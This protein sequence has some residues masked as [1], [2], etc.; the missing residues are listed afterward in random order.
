MGIL[1]RIYPPR[2]KT[3]LLWAVAFA[4][5][6]LLSSGGAQPYAS[7]SLTSSVLLLPADV[8]FDTG[9]NLFFSD[10]NRHVVQR[11]DPAGLVTIV[12]GS[13]VQGYAG[14]GGPALAAQLDCPAGLAVDA[15]GNLYIADTHNHRVRRV[16]GATGNIVTVAGTGRAGFTG[17]GGTAT[18]ARLDLP[19]A[20][21][22]DGTGNLYIADTNNHRVRRVAVGTGL[23][24]TVAGNGSQGFAGDGGSAT[25]A[26]IDS[27]GGVAVDA[28]GNLYIADAHNQR[29][30]MV[31]AKTGLISTV[32]GTGVAGFAGDGALAVGAQLA[33]PHGVSVDGAGNVY[34]ADTN[35]HRVR[36]IAPDG[37]MT[38]VAGD[39]VQAFRGDGGPAV[40]ASLN[41]PRGLAVSPTGLPTLADS[42]NQRVRQVEADRTIVTLAGVG[43]GAVP[44]VPVAPETLTLS[45]PE[46]VVY[47]SGTLTATLSAGGQA[48]GQ[49]T[50]YEG[51]GTTLGSV[52]VN[53]GQAAF[54]TGA[55]SAGTHQVYAS[56]AG[57]SAHAAAT[58]ATVALPVSPAP[59]IANVAA[60]YL[61]YGQSVPALAGTL[62]GVLPRDA[63]AVS[64][65]LTSA[66]RS[67]SSVGN[68]PVAASI[69]GAAAGNYA[70]RPPTAVLKIAKAGSVAALTD[71]ATT[72]TSGAPV[73]LTVHLASATSGVPTG[74]VTLMDGTTALATLPLSSTGDATYT[75]TSLAAG[76][77]PLV[78]VYAGDGNFNGSMTAVQ[79]VAVANPPAADFT[80]AATGAASQTVPA[81]TA[82]NYSFAVQMEGGTL[83]GPIALAASGLPAG[84]TA[85]FNPG[86][87]VPGGAGVFQLTVQTTKAI[88]SASLIGL[89]GMFLLPLLSAGLRRKLMGASCLCG[90][91]VLSGCGASMTAVAPAAKSYAITVLGTATSASGVVLQHTATVTLNIQ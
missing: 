34:V 87:V 28:A 38:T 11:I 69:S 16:D 65:Q 25:A 58:S 9:G 83:S 46:P 70:L 41:S 61:I 50:F 35:N 29:L 73:T 63:T 88:K 43:A 76:A 17:D 13:G 31:N 8:A 68:Y 72:V 79:T 33:L 2:R 48:G 80:I 40:A 59:L 82:A 7:S 14:D 10:T 64:L 90:L 74:A 5:L 53:G 62:A 21:A 23:M 32:A 39:G 86:T 45:V 36:R 4:A 57:D 81:G 42:A 78:G 89:G 26:G 1:S 12:A 66:A 30:R 54:G 71:S 44:V 55:L 27:P 22:L 49:V 15:A 75:S 18:A 91:M 84:T 37:T 6:T 51:A 52:P 19:T 85:S 20:L 3:G 47:G 67:L 56:Y 24:A 60:V 77:H